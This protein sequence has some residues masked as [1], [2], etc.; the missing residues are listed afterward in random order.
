MLQFFFLI[1]YFEEALPPLPL[2]RKRPLYIYKYYIILNN[3]HVISIG[4]P[5]LIPELHFILS[6]RE[7]EWDTIGQ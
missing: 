1:Q 3:M 6:E 2:W 4:T 7:N 5:H